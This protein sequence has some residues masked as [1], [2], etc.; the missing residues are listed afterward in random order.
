MATGYGLAN[1]NY[2]GPCHSCYLMP[3]GRCLGGMIDAR[4]HVSENGALFGDR[5]RR[6]G[7][8]QRRLGADRA[9]EAPPR[10]AGG[11]TAAG[12]GR[13]RDIVVTGT[14]VMRDGYQAPTPL[15]VLTTADIENSS[16]T[17]NIADF[18][19]QL[20]SLAGSTRPSNSR[21]NISS[22]QAGINALNLRNFGETRTLILLNG[23]RS[24]ASTIT[25]VVDV[26]TIPQMLVERVEIVTGGASAA[27]GSDAVAG[28]VNFILD[29]DFEGLRIEA[30]TGITSRGDGFNYSFSAAGGISFADGRGRLMVSGEIVASRR[31]LRRRRPRL[32][33]DG[34]RPDSGPDLDRR[35]HSTRN[36]SPPCSRSARRTRRRAAS[37][38]PRPAASRT[39]LRGIYFGGGGQVLQYQF[40]ALTFPSPTGD[41]RADADAGRR[42]AGQRFRPPHRP[43]PR[44]RSPRHLRP[45]ELR[46]RRRGHPVRRS[47]VQLAGSVL[48]RRPEPVHRPGPERDGL[49]RGDPGATL[50]S[51]ATP[52]ST[53]RSG[54]RRWRASPAS[55]SRRRP[56]IFPSAAINNQ[57]EVQRYV[58]GAEG[59]FELFGNTGAVGRLRPIWPRRPARAA[60]QHHADRAPTSAIGWP[61]PPTWRSPRPAI[62]AAMRSARSS[63]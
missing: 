33:P 14:R 8:G 53:T 26:N 25:G 45:A 28:V 47:L 52:S 18:V 19:N 60:A 46:G 16:P 17:N 9:G 32:E 61:T 12:R 13:A 40:G 42:L 4:F 15:T 63:A 48:Q 7:D 35:Q 5:L 44:G 2:G 50:R 10:R 57:R 39:G 1:R 59:D 30:D 21:L 41:R 31:H 22:G 51:P 24:V 43:R 38:P 20:P 54:R 55:P 58:V 37:S 27:Y 11:Q 6:D 62:P 23:R 36:S 56:P 3:A 49:R 34:L 29:N